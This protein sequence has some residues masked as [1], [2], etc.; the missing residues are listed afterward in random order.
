M[1]RLN[2]Q[3]RDYSDEYT[4][5]GVNVGDLVGLDVWSLAN[6]LADALAGH[7]GAHSTGTI[8]KVYHAQETQERDDSR[9]ADPYAQREL[10]IRFYLRD[11]VNSQMSFFTV[12]CADMTIGSIVAGQDELDLSASPTAAFVSWIETN[13]LSPDGN[14]VTVERAVVVGRSS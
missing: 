1:G 7:V 11:D 8:V 3:L 12:G 4:S 6:G 9:P 13:V 5:L 14:A 10:G 2:V